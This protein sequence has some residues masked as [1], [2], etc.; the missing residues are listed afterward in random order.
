[1]MISCKIIHPLILIQNN[2]SLK[3]EKINSVV[4]CNSAIVKCGVK[5]PLQG[6]HFACLAINGKLKVTRIILLTSLLF[7][8]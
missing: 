5:L 7:Q 8:L 6:N 3:F 2:T 1:M 4:V